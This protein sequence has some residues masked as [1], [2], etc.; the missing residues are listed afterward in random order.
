M[1]SDLIPAFKELIVGN[2]SLIRGVKG[3]QIEM[4]NDNNLPNAPIER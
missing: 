4:I 1:A 2:R 3:Y